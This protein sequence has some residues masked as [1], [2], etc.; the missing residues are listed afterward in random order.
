[1]PVAPEPPLF[2]VL[3]GTPI[4]DQVDAF[5]LTS[6]FVDAYRNGLRD[7]RSPDLSTFYEETPRSRVSN[8]DVAERYGAIQDAADELDIEPVSLEEFA[9]LFL[10]DGAAGKFIE[11]LGYMGIELNFTDDLLTLSASQLAFENAQTVTLIGE[12]TGRGRAQLTETVAALLTEIGKPLDVEETTHF[13]EDQTENNAIDIDDKAHE[14][15]FTDFGQYIEL[16][17][18]LA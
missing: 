18:K 7:L 10:P 5:D 2:E 1:M 3:E 17:V 12:Q 16:A 6:E 13:I 4:D 9:A 8:N 15:L 11:N 14:R